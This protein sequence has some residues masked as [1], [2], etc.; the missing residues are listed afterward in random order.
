MNRRYIVCYRFHCFNN[1]KKNEKCSDF[2]VRYYIECS[3]RE[4][5]DEAKYTRAKRS[6][7]ETAIVCQAET[8]TTLSGTFFGHGRKP[9]S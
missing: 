3:E 5:F 2:E 9:F 8:T 4:D 7:T 1:Y 6:S